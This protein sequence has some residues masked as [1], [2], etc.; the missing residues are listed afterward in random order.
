[1]GTNA[2]TKPRFVGQ[3]VKFKSP[4]AGVM[5]HDIAGL[6]TKYNRLEWFALNDLTRGKKD[7]AEVEA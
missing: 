7:R 1:M 5:L 3:I 4:H 2:Q 6:N